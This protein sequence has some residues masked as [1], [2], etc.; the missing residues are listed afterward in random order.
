MS[1]IFF[2]ITIILLFAGG[3]Y[4]GTGGFMLTKYEGYSAEH[5]EFE[6]LKR[7]KS[8][9]RNDINNEIKILSQLP[10]SNSLDSLISVKKYEVYSS[11]DDDEFFIG[12]SSYLNLEHY[13]VELQL[14]KLKNVFSWLYG[15]PTD[16][17]YF[18]T[19]CA[20][21]IVGGIIRLTRA[22]IIGQKQ[23]IQK[24]FQYVLMGVMMGIIVV[25]VSYILPNFLSSSSIEINST[26]LMFLSL[27]AGI[28]SE[29]F[30][31]RLEATFKSTFKNE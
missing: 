9:K 30:F 12:I 26:T 24:Q 5:A 8:R 21:G 18:L 14:N 20:F 15:L 27:F 4:L 3:L 7:I 23:T 11:Y 6:R 16:L 25:G 31:K 29:T 2:S 13:D 1:K 10:T 19:S 28:F 17:V 22:S